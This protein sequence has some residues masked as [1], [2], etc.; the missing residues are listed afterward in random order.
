VSTKIEWTHAPGTTGEA[1]NPVVGCTPVS[2][3]CENCY[4]EAMTLRF[5]KQ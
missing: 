3:G 5:W 2:E 1:W 4:A